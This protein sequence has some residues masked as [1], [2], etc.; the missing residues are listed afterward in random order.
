M[1]ATTTAPAWSRPG[2]TTRPTFGAWNATV[3]PARTASPATVPSDAST[4]D[5]T[6]RATT[7]QDAAF[8]A[9]TAAPIAPR[10]APVAPVPN[11]ASTATSAVRSNRRTAARSEVRITGMPIRLQTSWLVRASGDSRESGP[12]STVR[13]SSPALRRW[14][15]TTKPSPPL[16]PGP[17]T[18]VARRAA[19]WRC[20]TSWAAAR[21]ARSISTAPGMPRPS[22]AAAS[23]ERISAASGSATVPITTPVP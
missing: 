4:P 17:Q 8:S 12:T 23:S 21:P 19:G 1:S 15:A 13:T 10:G 9:A 20:S 18:I 7:G 22:I 14:R 11:S 5:G 6:S 3:H 16:L 2:A